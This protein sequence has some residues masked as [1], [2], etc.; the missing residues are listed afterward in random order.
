M[1]LRHGND[2][3]GGLQSVR[4]RLF[5]DHE[6]ARFQRVYDY[7]LVQ[8]R[9]CTHGDD[10]YIVS[11]KQAAIVGAGERNGVL[12]GGPLQLSLV[13]IGEAQLQRDR[14]STRL[15][16]SHIPLSRMPSS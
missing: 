8:D 11:I 14:K 16:S 10:I 2:P 3:V 13:D 1:L 5:A 9:R 15:N 6:L 7:T 12:A 4:Q